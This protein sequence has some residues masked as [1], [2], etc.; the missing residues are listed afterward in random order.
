MIKDELITRYGPVMTIN[1][2]AEVFHMNKNT[3]YNKIS[4]KTFEIDLFQVSG[5]L[6][7]ETSKVAEYIEH[8]QLVKR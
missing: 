1:D 8:Q 6:M 3:I 7:A 5:K 2:I 4:R